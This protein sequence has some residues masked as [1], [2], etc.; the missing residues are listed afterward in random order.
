[1]GISAIII[2]FAPP[3]ETWQEMKTIW[4]ACKKAK[5]DIPEKVLDFFG[6]CAPDPAG[7]EV[8]LKVHKWK[9]DNCDCY[10]INVADIP[11]HVK[12]IRVSNCW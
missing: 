10:D 11:K 1:M 2:G 3:D 12:V 8:K 4:D 5:I 7:V 9:N 6:G